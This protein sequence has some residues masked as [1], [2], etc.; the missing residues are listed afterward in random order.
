ML[1]YLIWR[2]PLTELIFISRKCV[3]VH[4]FQPLTAPKY[5]QKEVHSISYTPHCG[6]L[7]FSRILDIREKTESF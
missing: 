7:I 2:F 4:E 6:E 5:L 1:Y 3:T